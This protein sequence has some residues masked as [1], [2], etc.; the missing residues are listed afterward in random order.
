MIPP[1]VP[2]ALS[3]VGGLRRG[4][5]EAP[6]T[7]PIQ[8]VSDET[9]EATLVELPEV[10]ADMVRLQR[11]TAARPAEICSLRPCDLDRSEEVWTY[12]PQKHKTQHHGKTRKIFIGPKG[13]A[14]LLR[15][16]V[17]DAESH[18]F[19]PAD[20]KE[21]RRAAIHAKR[22]TPLSYGNKPGSKRAKRG[23]PQ[24]K[25]QPG[26]RYITD[27]YRRAIHRAC[28]RAFP[29]PELASINKADRTAE[30]QA[31]IQSWQSSKRWSPLRHSAATEIRAKFGLEEAQV[32]LGHSAADVTKS[33]PNAICRRA[34]KSH[35][36]SDNGH[37]SLVS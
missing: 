24:A 21:K 14:I 1:D 15:Y 36:G 32:I 30:Q 25:W 33:P 37:C 23:M 16:L 13:Q 9:V 28:D 11:L 2:A 35:G 6:E 20:S 4:R 3:M 34:S 12:Q 8:P 29:H 7:D 10:V 19:R 26:D 27:S 18:C 5:T 22:K 31:E 17:R